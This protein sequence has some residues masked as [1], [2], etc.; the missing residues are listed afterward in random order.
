MPSS[1]Y[2]AISFVADELLTSTKM[3]QMA[4]NDAS[5]NTM[6]GMNDDVLALR[7]IP[8]ALI[9]SAKMALGS[10]IPEKLD[11]SSI[12]II[13]SAAGTSNFSST[14]DIQSVNVVIPTGCTKALIIGTV[15]LQAQN[16]STQ[17]ITTWVDYD[18]ATAVTK[19]ST[20]TSVGTTFASASVSIV[21]IIT[22]SAGT[23]A[24]KIRASTGGSANVGSRTVLV[25]PI[26]A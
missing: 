11:L 6:A 17:D 3:N 24:F 18:A 26:K 22:V 19:S 2:T 5:F 21:D 15:R 4:A 9:T 8:A 1:G 12:G 25:I 23:K 16:G 20:F 10:V 7:H 13:A 14:T